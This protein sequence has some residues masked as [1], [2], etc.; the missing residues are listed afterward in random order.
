MRRFTGWLRRRRLPPA[1]EDSVTTAARAE[2]EARERQEREERL[3]SAQQRLD[4][5][6]LRLQVQ[7]RDTRWG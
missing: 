6:Q 4:A 7:Q 3:Q 5:L 2:I 1:G